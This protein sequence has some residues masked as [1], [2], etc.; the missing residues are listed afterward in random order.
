MAMDD[1]EHLKEEYLDAASH[2]Y[3]KTLKVA[4]SRFTDT[5]Q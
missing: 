5:E 4:I 3:L 1:Q 2:G